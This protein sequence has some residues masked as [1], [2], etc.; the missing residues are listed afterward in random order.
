MLPIMNEGV[1]RERLAYG[2]AGAEDEPEAQA[3]LLAQCEHEQG[4]ARQEQRSPDALERQKKINE[5]TQLS[6]VLKKEIA[7]LE[8]IVKSGVKVEPAGGAY[9]SANEEYANALEGAFRGLLETKKG[10]LQFLNSRWEN[11]NKEK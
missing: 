2:P 5:F 11:W 3:K 8:E 7:E 6:E 4:A 10:E 1:K 9:D